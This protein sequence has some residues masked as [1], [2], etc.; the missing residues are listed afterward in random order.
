MGFIGV[1]PATVPFTSSDITDGIITTAKISDDAVTTSK[2][3]TGTIVQVVATTSTTAVNDAGAFTS[4]GEISTNFRRAI[5]P[6]FASSNLL[7]ETQF[8]FNQHT[9]S[10][11]LVQQFKFYDVTN[12]ADVFV[13]D[14][15]G[16]RNRCTIAHRHSH[17]DQNDP[18]LVNMRAFIPA[19]NTTARTYTI[20][21]RCEASGTNY[22]F[23]QSNGDSSGYG[24]TCPF[25]FTIK[26][27]KA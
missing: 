17:Y 24:F 7:L 12:T 9:G 22:D 14:T 27:I 8:M 16:S 4:F 6:L 25:L 1:Q 15:L 3:P 5:T 21:M 26:E 18:D 11:T 19:S 10:N 23:I 2:L 13:G 20:H